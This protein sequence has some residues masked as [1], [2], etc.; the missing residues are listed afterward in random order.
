M[1]LSRTRLNRTDLFC[2]KKRPPT[3]V[4][5]VVQFLLIIVCCTQRCSLAPLHARVLLTPLRE[6]LSSYKHNQRHDDLILNRVKILQLAALFIPQ[7]VRPV[8]MSD[9]VICEILFAVGPRSTYLLPSVFL[10]SPVTVFP[11]SILPVHHRMF[12]AHLALGVYQLRKVSSWRFL[13]VMPCVRPVR[14]DGEAVVAAASC[15]P[16]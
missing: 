4:N 15:D 16:K 10:V 2:E 3:A 1:V 8:A 6:P 9:D 14:G 13:S 11:T 7:E 5:R 12:W